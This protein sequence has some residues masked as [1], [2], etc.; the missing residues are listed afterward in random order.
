MTELSVSVTVLVELEGGRG[1]WRAR[2]REGEV[3]NFTLEYSNCPQFN[4]LN[5]GDKRRSLWKVEQCL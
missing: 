1:G 5:W 4:K 2:W 3:E